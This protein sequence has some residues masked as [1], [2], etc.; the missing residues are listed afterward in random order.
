MFKSTKKIQNYYS[1]HSQ[2][3]PYFKL[4]LHFCHK[5]FSPISFFP[6][7]PAYILQF[8][9]SIIKA[10]TVH[11]YDAS[12][13]FFLLLSFLIT[14]LLMSRN[15]KK[16]TQQQMNIWEL[17]RNNHLLALSALSLKTNVSVISY[18][19]Q[20]KKKIKTYEYFFVL[21]NLLSIDRTAH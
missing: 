7:H 12:F 18:A 11:M 20:K 19:F 3:R 4:K 1:D 6:S 17:W 10:N 14:M 9:S 8:K 16:V 15:D 5:F 2:V 21:E 13:T